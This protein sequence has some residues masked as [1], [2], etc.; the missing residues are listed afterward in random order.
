V[1]SPESALD[2]QHIDWGSV[3]AEQLA[4]GIERQM[5][6]GERLMMCRLIL[7]PQVVTAVHSHPHEQMTI[8]A[9]GRVRFIVDG[10]DRIAT[11][12]DVLLFPANIPHG[13]TMLDEEVELI[14]IFSP[15]REDFLPQRPQPR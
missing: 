6:W 11:A 10:R 13:A 8:V 15:L 3:P 14:D 1:K 7:Q 2:Y 5:I 12:G 4:E 9:R